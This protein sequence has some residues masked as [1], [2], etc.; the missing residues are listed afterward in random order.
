MDMT[1]NLDPSYEYEGIDDD[2]FYAEINR[3]I[4]RLTADDEETEIF[5]P[6]NASKPGSN[7]AVGNIVSSL[8]YG[9]YFS[10]WE[11]DNN[12]QRTN[13]ACKSVEN[14]QRNW[15]FYPPSQQI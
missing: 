15:S 1:M 4:L 14:W 13:S 8:Q 12:K 2:V 9:S 11:S 7:S 5:L 6:V 3:Q 10:S